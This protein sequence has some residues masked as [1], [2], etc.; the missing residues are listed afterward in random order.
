MVFADLPY[1]RR[2]YDDVADLHITITLAICTVLVAA[3]I[4]ATLSQSPVTIAR[5]STTTREP[6]L[7][8]HRPTTVASPTKRF[9]GRPR[10]FGCRYT[11]FS[12]RG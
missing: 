7:T 10:R 12:A 1:D 3:A 5:A 4:G 9:R 6:I 11:P 2:R 8:T